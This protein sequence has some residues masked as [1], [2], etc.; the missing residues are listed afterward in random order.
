MEVR[1]T[2]AIIEI[3]EREAKRIQI[4]LDEINQ[5]EKSIIF[6]ATQANAAAIRDLIT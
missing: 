4:I 3:R 5:K 1:Y 6:C 2:F